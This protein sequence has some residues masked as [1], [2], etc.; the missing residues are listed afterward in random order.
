MK[1]VIQ[2]PCYNEEQTLPLVIAGIPKEIPG[3][4]LIEIVIVD[5]GSTDKTVAVAQSLG[6]A[7]VYSNTGNL[8]LAFTFRKA[9]DLSLQ[10]G[11]DI[12]VNMDGDNQYKGSDIARLIAPI[13]NRTADMV[14]GDRQTDTIDEFSPL[15]KSLQKLGSSVIRA[16]STTTVQDTTSGFR[17]FSRES[18]FKITVLSN[19]TYTHETIL[20]A[21]SKGLVIADVPITVNRKTRDSRLFKSIRHYLLFSGST[22]IRIF[23]MYNPLRFFFDFGAIFL[24]IGGTLVIRF[25]IY[26]LLGDGS[27]KIQSL[28]FA[29]V[30]LVGGIVIMLTGVLAD[31]MQ[32]NRRILE[33]VLERVRKLERERTAR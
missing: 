22:I 11:A 24:L 32:F 14:V 8:G 2:I 18:A 12:I 20:Q 25:L 3:I 5:D 26:Y 4:S 10:R 28:I 29:S 17:A 1:L 9:L 16:L 27:G 23:A 7:Q 30:F 33:E 15:K 6:V 31:I 21:H 19:F 13:M